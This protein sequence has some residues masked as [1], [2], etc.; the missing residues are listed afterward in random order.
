MCRGAKMRLTVISTPSVL[1]GISEHA[2]A[3]RCRA[4]HLLGG[5]G[6]RLLSEGGRA[7]QTGRREPRFIA[8]GVDGVS[9]PSDSARPNTAATRLRPILLNGDYRIRVIH[10][11]DIPKGG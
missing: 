9:R 8:F 6:R 10:R 1:A 4:N 2:T 7:H 3:S 5:K 11:G